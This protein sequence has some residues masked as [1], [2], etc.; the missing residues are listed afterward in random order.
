MVKRNCKASSCQKLQ[1]P[2]GYAILKVLPFLHSGNRKEVSRM[3]EILT[4]II[5]AVVAQVT[6]NY[7]CKWLDDHTNGK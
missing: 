1:C 4:N 2:V 7:V 6:A 5:V 3:A